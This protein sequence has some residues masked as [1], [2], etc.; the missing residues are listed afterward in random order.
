[1]ATPSDR[2]PGS[3][4]G[5]GES[6]PSKLDALIAGA[7][8]SNV[9]QLP[10]TAMVVGPHPLEG[11]EDVNEASTLIAQMLAEERITKEVR[12]YP[13]ALL[14]Q[15]HIVAYMLVNPFASTTDICGY[16]QISPTTLS[17]IAKSDTFKA[18]VNKHRVGVESIMPDLQDQIRE[19]LRVAVEVTGRAVVER[20]TQ[21]AEFALNVADKFANRL[22]MGAKQGTNVQINN[23]I[24][25]P[26]ML[27]Q[28]RARRS[29]S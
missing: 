6:A 27:Q 4:D 29:H 26:E 13:R 9:T 25:T 14:R 5:K 17:N 3:N 2:L 11:V 10:G 12:V 23:N 20:G 22:G 16:F 18:M 7:V 28:A 24:L 19:T 15:Q 21:D 1:M 8:G